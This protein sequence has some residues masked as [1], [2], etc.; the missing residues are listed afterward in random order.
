[1]VR[2]AKPD[3]FWFKVGHLVKEIFTSTDDCICDIVNKLN[4]E[5][6]DAGEYHSCHHCQL[7]DILKDVLYS[8]YKNEVK[9]ADVVDVLRSYNV[10]NLEIIEAVEA[11]DQLKKE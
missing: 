7:V 10:A 3:K 4:E 11:V 1:M 6:D 2:S 5:E 8:Y 9:R